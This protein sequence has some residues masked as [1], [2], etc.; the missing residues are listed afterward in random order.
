M[1]TF[2]P[3]QQDR[4][5]NKKQSRKRE[6]GQQ[7]WAGQRGQNR[8]SGQADQAGEGG[9][10][11]ATAK[12]PAHVGRGNQ[13]KR[14]KRTN[15]SGQRGHTSDALQNR[16]EGRCLWPTPEP[17]FSPLPPDLLQ[18]LHRLPEVLA[19]VWPLNT[20]HRRSLPGDV[21]ALSRLLTVER[22]ELHRPYWATPASVS[23]YLYY[24]LPW[25][26]IRLGR[27]LARLPLPDPRAVAPKGGAALF[28]DVG[29]GPLSLPLA[30]WMARPEWRTIPV[31][32]LAL[33]SA[34]RPP[35]L[36]RAIM[37]GL[38][39]RMG[40]PAWTV[41]TVCGPLE[42]L[43][44][45]AA[46]L[47]RHD[48]VWLVSAANVLNELR[49]SRRAGEAGSYDEEHEENGGERSGSS[50][51]LESVLDA[52]APLLFSGV[53]AAEKPS[54]AAAPALLFVE[55][56]TRL[57]GTTIMR[58]REL[59]VEGGLTPAS[60]C[61]HA[62]PCPLLEGQGGRTWCHFTFDSNGAPAWLRRLSEEAGLAKTGLSLS[63]LLLQAAGQEVDKQTARVISA[64][65]FVPG[66]RGRGRYAC[67]AQ[68]LALL[69]DAENL[70]SGASLPLPLPASGRRDAKSRAL[71][72]SAPRK[73]A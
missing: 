50:A 49:P 73:G 35:E 34:A 4:A 57:G 31:R 44:R 47:L 48:A 63:P 18:A 7:P 16:G 20:A 19:E 43:P 24:F 1:S 6:A 9:G 22:R 46:P 45:Q 26:L 28:M 64:P 17:L 14:D 69:E 3:R 61:P 58:L 62:G 37:E 40:W 27:L 67:T 23:A 66:L 32:V 5:S 52:L 54:L 41:R 21:A 68:G 2:S 59:A 55:P 12:A 13:D 65:F 33:D 53:A 38:S 30:L 25:N 36:G 42:S 56:G 39:R 11:P 60:P 71:I 72:I 10:R 8:Q 70:P 29:S 15:G 51:R